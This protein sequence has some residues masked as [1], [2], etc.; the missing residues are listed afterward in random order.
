M[1]YSLAYCVYRL[2]RRMQC[3]ISVGK[4]RRISPG[5]GYGQRHVVQMCVTMPCA[6]PSLGFSLTFDNLGQIRSS[7]VAM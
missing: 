2:L 1:L 3:S 4:G 6:M 5:Q 7:Y